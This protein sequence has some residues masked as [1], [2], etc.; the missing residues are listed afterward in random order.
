MPANSRIDHPNIRLTPLMIVYGLLAVAGAVVPWYF[1]IRF[2]VETGD[3]LTYDGLFAAGFATLL[4]SSLTSDFIIGSTAVLVWMV[5]DA[6]RL[7]MR[8]WWVYLAVTF[9]IA[10]ASACP[11]YLLMRERRL[12]QMRSVG[13]TNNP[14]A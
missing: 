4:A 1:N 12:Q 6:R 2:M 13:T 3:M 8:H 5:V 14:S 11:L 9:L 7:G 10:F